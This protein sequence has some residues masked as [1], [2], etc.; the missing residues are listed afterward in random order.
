[1]TKGTDW[2]WLSVRLVVGVA[3][4]LQAIIAVWLVS[5][6]LASGA[7]GFDWTVL[8]RAG[9][10]VAA[11]LNP[12]E[13]AYRWHP[14][15]AWLFYVIEPLGIWAWRAANLAS[16]MWLGDWRLIAAALLSW[17]LWDAV[18]QGNSTLIIV[19]VG[20]AALAGQRSAGLVFLGLCVMVPRPWVLPAVF[21]LLRTQP[22]LRW[23]GVAIGCAGLASAL[24]TGWAGEWI[25]VLMG[26]GNE[27]SSAWNFG[28][29]RLVGIA[30]LVIG[31]PLAAW[32]AWRGHV[33]FAGLAFSPYL[34]AQYYLV[35][36]WEARPGAPSALPR[37]DG[38]L[39]SH[40]RRSDIRAA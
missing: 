9:Q 33:G 29:S 25:V 27:I 22:Q 37:Y 26:S 5:R 8:T 10:R 24:A 2:R 14:L 19:T 38:L 40:E 13:G 6:M 15:A 36:L 4:A 21:W 32:L 11:D 28:P 3:F 31:V 18:F 7:P 35:L 30:W 16:L 39:R 34:F 1:M 17:P 12:Y 23:P 20:F